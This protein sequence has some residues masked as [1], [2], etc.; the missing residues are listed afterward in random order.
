MPY[1]RP[2]DPETLR[3]ENE[4]R[5]RQ[6]EEE[7]GAR[8]GLI[9]PGLPPEVENQFLRNILEFERQFQQREQIAIY[10]FIGR[11]PF[12]LPADISGEDEYRAELER[13]LGILEEHGIVLSVLGQYPAGVIY[14]FVTEELFPY[15]KDNIRLPGFIS[16]FIYEEFHPNHA[17]VLEERVREFFDGL[18]HL[19]ADWV[20][21]P[22]LRDV[23]A[24]DGEIKGEMALQHWLK[25]FQ[26]RFSTLEVRQL[27]IHE[28]HFDLDAREGYAGFS[29]ELVGQLGGGDAWQGGGPGRFDFGYEHDYW[30]ISR[31]DLQ[32]MRSSGPSAAAALL[33]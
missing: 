25:E 2:P 33:P 9:N 1:N 23:E 21:F 8:F 10:D 28:L 19:D 16:N 24:A 13:L 6:L 14:R 11:P 29:V 27:H 5:K 3:Q 7:F 26:S 15:E 20:Y 17:L 31:L 32:I 12:R 18:G 4:S 30:C 22:F